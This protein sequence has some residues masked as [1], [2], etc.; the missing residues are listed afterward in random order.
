MK[1][2]RSWRELRLNKTLDRQLEQSY[3][4]DETEEGLANSVIILLYILLDG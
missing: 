1:Q 4:I 2:M 3:S